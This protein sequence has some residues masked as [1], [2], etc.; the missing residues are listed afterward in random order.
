MSMSSFLQ[1]ETAGLPNWTWIV[2][3]GGGIALA[4]IVPK[5]FSSSQ[6]TSTTSPSSA[7]AIDPTTGMLFP[8]NGIQSLSA[9]SSSSPTNST[10]TLPPVSSV[11]STPTPTTPTTPPTPPTPT[12]TI[13]PV[14]PQKPVTQPVIQQNPQEIFVTVTPW[15]T[16]LS[17][18]WGIAQKYGLSLQR[19][20]QLNP[21]IKN[22]NLIYPGQKVRIA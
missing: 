10:T 4:Y 21:Q 18:L 15:P 1:Q 3:A 7:Y 14:G 22:P 17:T 11:P 13:Q 16:P 6:T 19:I 12:T 9:G 2:V 20:E 8:I 5:F